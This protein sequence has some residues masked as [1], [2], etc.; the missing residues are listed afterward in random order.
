M[1]LIETCGC[2]TME[3]LRRSYTWT[4][5]HLVQSASSL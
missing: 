2:D 5:N 1:K 4:T 3:T